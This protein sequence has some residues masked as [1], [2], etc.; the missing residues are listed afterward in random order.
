MLSKLTARPF[1]IWLLVSVVLLALGTV[2]IGQTLWL[3]IPIIAGQGCVGGGGLC[4]PMAPVLGLWLQPALL[5]ASVC[6]GTIAFYRRGLAVGSRFWALMP[7]ALMLPNL[8]SLFVLGN[9]WNLDLGSALLFFPRWSALELLPL[10]MLGVLFCFQVEYMPGYGGSIARTRLYGNIPIG[11]LYIA[12]CLWICSDLL[13]ASAPNLGMSIAS[14]Q[15]LR[16]ILHYPLSLVDGQVLAGLPPYGQRPEMIVPLGT[17][18]N[19][20]L[21]AV[22]VFALTFDGS[23]RLRRAGALIFITSGDEDDGKPLFQPRSRYGR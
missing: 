12:S 15:A 7:L 2:F 18:V 10:L 9:L 23:G 6:L 5:L 20:V 8:P 19:L 14:V 17:L 16:G 22:L 3:T 11:P 1:I 13:L 4:G 21:F